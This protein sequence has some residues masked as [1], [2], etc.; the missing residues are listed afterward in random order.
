MTNE[1]LIGKDWKEPVVVQLTVDIITRN[2]SGE[3]DEI[4]DKVSQYSRSPGRDLNTGPPEY[5]TGLK[6]KM[7]LHS[8]KGPESLHM[9]NNS[10]K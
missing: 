7:I 4:H 6:Y 9:W 5:E 1:K 2:L 8:L 3:T 10:V